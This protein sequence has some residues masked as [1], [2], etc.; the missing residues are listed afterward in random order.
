MYIDLIFIIPF[1]IVLKFLD[2]YLTVW[3]YKNYEHFARKF[4][5]LE[6]YEAN[7]NWKK[8]VEHGFKDWR[9]YSFVAVL[10]VMLSILY[11]LQLE[12]WY[13]FFTGFSLFL[14]LAI[15]F[16]HLSHIRDME[17][18]KGRVKGKILYTLDYYF[19]TVTHNYVKYSAILLFSWIVT[20]N[21]FLL[22]A[23]FGPLLIATLIK[24]RWQ[25]YSE[26]I[27]RK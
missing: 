16:E 11:F 1:L 15:N 23:I 8:D 9:H 5:V 21:D 27:K 10:I 14:Y 4:V 22:G 25:V 17:M 6:S 12:F 2:S 7:P 20:Q 26:E 24:L 18:I 19:S 13:T 3:A